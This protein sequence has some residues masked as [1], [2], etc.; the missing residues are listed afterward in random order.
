MSVSLLW[1]CGPVGYRK[2]L[3]E[4]GVAFRWDFIASE[5]TGRLRRYTLVFETPSREFHT[6]SP[7]MN[8]WEQAHADRLYRIYRPAAVLRRDL[9]RGRIVDALRGLLSEQEQAEVVAASLQWRTA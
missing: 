9:P 1:I 5:S 4:N 6:I 2:S 7:K 3:I 8:G